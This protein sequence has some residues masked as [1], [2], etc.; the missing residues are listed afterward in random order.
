M[1]VLA[2]GGFSL[3]FGDLRGLDFKVC[4]FGFRV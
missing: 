2:F 1:G 3:S 4:G